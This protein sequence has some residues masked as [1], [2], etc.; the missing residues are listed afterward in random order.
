M[1]LQ[2][3]FCSP[4]TNFL[5]Y[6]KSFHIKFKFHFAVETYWEMMDL[7]DKFQDYTRNHW[8]TKS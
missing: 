5:I 7:R 3:C 2:Y 1:Y 6:N 8:A 4:D